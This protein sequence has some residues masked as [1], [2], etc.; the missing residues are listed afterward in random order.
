MW[1]LFV[2]LILPEIKEIFYEKNDYEIIA[3]NGGNFD[4]H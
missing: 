3:G 2:I 4:F 1:K